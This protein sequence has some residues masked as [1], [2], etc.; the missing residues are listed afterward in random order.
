L[1]ELLNAGEAGIELTENLAMLPAASVSG[2]YFGHPDA[3][4]FAIGPVQRDQVE[5][6]AKENGI[7]VAETER[8][9]APSLG[10]DAD[11]VGEAAQ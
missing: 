4:Y 9:I 8:R 3:R 11:A 6:Y 2:L 10:Y 5:A 7:S 1:F